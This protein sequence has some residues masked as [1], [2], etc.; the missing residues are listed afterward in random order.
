MRACGCACV[1]ACFLMFVS[2]SVGEGERVCMSVPVCVRILR[3]RVRL[4]LREWIR[5]RVP[6]F[7]F[8]R[9][10]VSA[11]VR[12]CWSPCVRVFMCT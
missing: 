9:L 8:L 2:V 7:V 11:C 4:S 10:C 3:S 12:V 6:A 1:R 5:E